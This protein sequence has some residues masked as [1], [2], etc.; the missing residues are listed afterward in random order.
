MRE[1]IA[2]LESALGSLEQARDELPEDLRR[3]LAP[4]LEQARA[5]LES[6][7]GKSASPEP[8]ETR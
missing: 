6:I 2:A 8:S 5:V 4:I 1:A 3:E 7:R